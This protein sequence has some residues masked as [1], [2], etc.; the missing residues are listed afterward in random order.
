MNGPLVGHVSRFAWTP[1]GHFTRDGR[2]VVFAVSMSCGVVLLAAPVD[3]SGSPRVLNWPFPQ[4][5]GVLQNSSGI[6]DSVAIAPGGRSVFFLGEQDTG[7]VVELYSAPIDGSAQPRKW[8][9]PLVAGGN[10]TA[11]APRP[12]PGA[13]LYRADQDVDQ[14]FELYLSELPDAPPP[15]TRR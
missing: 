5:G 3:G 6:L 10:V 15:H 1:D 11:F 14:R 12:G 8:N 7:G 9:A 13:V 4:G 2:F